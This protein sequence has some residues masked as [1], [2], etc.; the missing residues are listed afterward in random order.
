MPR[1]AVAQQR[2]VRRASLAR[3]SVST[4]VRNP[5]YRAGTTFTATVTNAG[6][7]VT[8]PTISYTA[9]GS[10]VSVFFTNVTAG[11]TIWVNQSLTNGQVLVV[12]FSARTVTV[13]GVAVS[14]VLSVDS[15]WWDLAVGANTIRS[16][17]PASV[18]HRDAFS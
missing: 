6:T 14:G 12:D 5:S 7:V 18:S 8:A 11:K 3:S 1:R 15:R 4:H 9:V 16:N 10:W 13:D 17:V 2:F